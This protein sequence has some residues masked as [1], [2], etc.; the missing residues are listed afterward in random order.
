MAG[1]D[2]EPNEAIAM[3]H[4]PISKQSFSAWRTIFVQQSSVSP[5]ELE[6]YQI[7]LEARGGYF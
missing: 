5:D 2:R 4:A 3:G 6:G 7:W 1:I